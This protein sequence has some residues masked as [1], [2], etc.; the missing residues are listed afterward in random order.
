MARNLGTLTVDLV[1]KIGGFT[2]GLSKAEREAQRR[3]KSI[4]DS[5]S[6]IGKV[7]ITALATAGL[8]AAAALVA[9]SRQAIDT[10]DKVND[11]SKITGI[12]TETLSQLGYAAQQSGSDMDSLASALPKFSKN[13]AEAAAGTK[14]QA[15]AFDA[16]GV[17]V[18]DAEGKIK[19][20]DMLLL[21]VADKFASYEDGAGKAAL[22]QEFFGK[23]GAELIPF[24]NNGA[25]AISQL[26]MESD[27]LGNT[28]SGNTAAA[29]DEF[30]DNLARLRTVAVGLGNALIT[31]VLPTLNAMTGQLDGTTDKTNGLKVAVQQILY[32]FRALA[33]EIILT[34]DF[35]GSF[36]VAFT[37]AAEAVGL[38]AEGRFS[39]AVDALKKG[40]QQIL[41]DSK[42]AAERV[43]MI[44]GRA[45]QGM[46]KQSEEN[47]SAISLQWRGLSADVVNYSNQ[48]MKSGI[49]AGSVLAPG[50]SGVGGGTVL[51]PGSTGDFRLGKTQAPLT[52]DG[53]GNKNTEA[54]RLQNQYDDLADSLR[55]QILLYGDASKASKLRYETEVGDLS[56]LTAA[57]KAALIAQAEQLDALD[58][59]KAD[60]ELGAGQM[61][62]LDALR[63]RYASENEIIYA[64]YQE[65]YADLETFRELG[66]VSEQEYAELS[67]QIN[68]EKN[69]ALAASDKAY[70]DLQS[71]AQVQALSAAAEL[72]GNLTGLIREAG[73]EQTAIGK[74]LFIASKGIAVATA[75][76]Q[77]NVA[78][79]STMA[80]Y[81][82]AA[83][84]AGP[85][86]PAIIAAGLAQAEL[87]RGIG[88]A[89]AAVIAAT[90]VASFEG[91]GYTGS[92]SRTGGEDGKGGFMAMLHPNES[93]IDHTKGQGMSGVTVNVVESNDKAGQVNKNRQPDGSMIIDVF[94]ADVRSGGPMSNAMAGTFGL[95]RRGR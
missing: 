20:M 75:I 60:Q 51:A 58:A 26:A 88:L 21:E 90:A 35:I 76:I 84:F 68:Q 57:Q 83:S 61:D 6:T 71:Q 55:Q 36:G 43:E 16:I 73:L 65:R 40:N 48:V 86:A 12:S 53:T 1:A 77:A 92:G 59:M 69:E 89:N 72:A 52:G 11:L 38:A 9:I 81:A 27:N 29:A 8:G 14:A 5:L 24:L 49:G 82:S 2:E 13:I 87:I 23:S 47:L 32:P 33:E 74:A 15:A 41:D 17:S 50:V 54:D 28:I 62:A 45:T 44:W 30:N 18:T 3:S 95:S 10:A 67:K 39:D 46:K 66:L 31:E 78:A 7:G 91:G 80:A 34:S 85:A 56:K 4:N 37:A 79:T 70:A 63:E 94:V 19:P 93:V 22:A 42:S 64:A 25:A